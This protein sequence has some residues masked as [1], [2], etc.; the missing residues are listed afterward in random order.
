MRTWPHE[1]LLRRPQ[2]KDNLRRRRRHVQAQAART[3]SVSLSSLKRYA[4]KARRRDSLAPKKSPGSPRKL[5]EK[6][7]KLLEDDLAERPRQPAGPLRLHGGRDG[8]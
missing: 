5:E 1:R 2:T 4:K 6:A 7:E 3:F 8:S